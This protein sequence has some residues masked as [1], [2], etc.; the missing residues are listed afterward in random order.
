[1]DQTR[2][3]CRIAWNAADRTCAED[4]GDIDDP[5]GA[6]ALGEMLGELARHQPGALEIS[7]ENVIPFLLGMLQYRLCDHDTGI[8]D[9]DAEWPELPLGGCDGSGDAGRPSDV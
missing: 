6:L 8:V 2:L 4:G 3:R 5:P 1:M 9:E 7:V